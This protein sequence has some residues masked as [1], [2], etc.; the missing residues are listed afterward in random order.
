MTQTRRRLVSALVLACGLALLAQLQSLTPEGVFYNGDGGTKYLLTRQLAAGRQAPD[1]QLDG[2]AWAQALWR[3]GLQPLGPAF[4]LRRDQRDWIAFPVTFPWLSAPALRAFGFPGL[5]LL[6]GLATVGTWLLVAAAARRLRLS[7]AAT[8]VALT[9]V[10]FGTPLTTYGAIFWEHAPA[11]T[12][13]FAGFVLLSSPRRGTPGAAVAALAGLLVSLSVWLREE[14]LALAVVL[15]ALA[16]VGLLE[17]PRARLV[18]R[19]YASS[20]RRTTSLGLLAGLGAGLVGYALMNQ[21]VYGSLW[22]VRDAQ[23]PAHYWLRR[24]QVAAGVLAF[25]LPAFVRTFPLVLLLPFVKL[26]WPGWRWPRWARRLLLVAA[27]FTLLM[28]P[29]PLIPGGKQIGPRYLLALY[30]LAAL[31]AGAAWD[32]AWRAQAR[33]PAFPRAPRAVLVSLALACTLWSLIAGSWWAPRDLALALHKRALTLAHMHRDPQRVVAVSHPFVAQQLTWYFGARLF[34]L[35]R[36]GAD[37]KALAEAQA[38]AGEPVGFTYLCNPAYVCP[39]FEHEPRQRVLRMSHN[40]ALV[41]L[42]RADVGPYLRWEVAPA[43][44]G[45]VSASLDV[46]EAV[47]AVASETPAPDRDPGRPIDDGCSEAGADLDAEALHPVLALLDPR[48]VLEAL[49]LAHEMQ[50]RVVADARGQLGA[51]PFPAGPPEKV[52]GR[53]GCQRGVLVDLGVRVLGARARRLQRAQHRGQPQAAL[54]GI[55]C[56]VPAQVAH[57]LKGERAA[58]GAQ[59]R[60]HV[61]H[62]VVPG[63]QRRRGARVLPADHALELVDVTPFH[64]RAHELQARL[65]A[66]R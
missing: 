10:I 46:P 54:V 3:D 60:H 25:V 49:D 66:R 39:G 55:G 44:P 22:G 38:L 19:L 50:G 41:A 20:W 61:D 47:T 33:G 56:R 8:L 14:L 34:F 57:E 4:V 5:L 28:A 2:P 26:V 12:L 62:A 30:P 40:R 63:D 58:T 36:R 13:A 52:V 23:L 6:P 45:L 27:A 16:L 17:R 53:I 24:P 9:L 15:A 37:L 64:K 48:A 35:T 1:L 51:V 31:L 43:A 7:T 32:A 21:A 42:R 65:R 59:A 29:L 11:V 18:R